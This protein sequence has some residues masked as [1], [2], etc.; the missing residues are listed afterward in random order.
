M[1]DDPEL[2]A[3]KINRLIPIEIGGLD[4]SLTNS[5]LFMVA[6]VAGGGR[7]PLSDDDEPRPGAVA[8]PVHLR[9]VV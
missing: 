8:R 4:F 3:S 2:S 6:T 5:S 1:A 7:V 9:N